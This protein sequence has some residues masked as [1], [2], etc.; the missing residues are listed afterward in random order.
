V[1]TA[2]VAARAPLVGLTLAPDTKGVRSVSNAA[3]EAK[4]TS[5]M[6]AAL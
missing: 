1:A 3:R 2:A 5:R 6:S 4:R